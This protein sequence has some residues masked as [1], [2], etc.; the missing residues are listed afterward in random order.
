MSDLG[1]KVVLEPSISGED[2]PSIVKYA[3]EKQ[4]DLA[5]VGP[6]DPLCLGAVDELQ[7][8]GIPGV[9]ADAGRSPAGGGQGVRQ[10]LMQQRSVPTA[11]TR[12]FSKYS[13][14]KRYVASRDS[15]MVIKAAGLAKGKGA[16]VCDD[17]RRRCWRWSGS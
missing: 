6:E 15:G 2:V 16:I 9:R 5:V 1:E 3:R 17:P 14:A 11:D 10:E 8:A 4:I 12:V 7:K 13:D